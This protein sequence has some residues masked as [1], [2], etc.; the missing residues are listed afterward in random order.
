MQPLPVKNF[1]LTRLLPG[2]KLFKGLDAV[3]EPE[4]A[5]G[6]IDQLKD[7]QDLLFRR[8]IVNGTLDMFADVARKLACKAVSTP[9]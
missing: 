1:Y 9:M 7:F 2:E 4:R 5:A 8:S 3:R 6:R